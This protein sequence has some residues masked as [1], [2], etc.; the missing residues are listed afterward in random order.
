MDSIIKPLNAKVTALSNHVTGIIYR[1]G[2]GDPNAGAEL[3]A[4]I[5][6]ASNIKADF[7]STIATLQASMKAASGLQNVAIMMKMIAFFVMEIAAAIQLM[8]SIIKLITSIISISSIIA[9]FMK[10][11][12]AFQAA[13]NKAILWLKRKLARVKEKIMKKLEWEKRKITAR[14]MMAYLKASQTAMEKL[15][16]NL[17]PKPPT[18]GENGE[19]VLEDGSLPDTGRYP[20]YMLDSRL[21]YTPGTFIP[22][23]LTDKEK[24]NANIDA[25]ALELVKARLESTKEE[26]KFYEKEIE[27]SSGNID[28]D[29]G[30]YE[31]KWDKETKEDQ[32][33]ITSMFKPLPIPS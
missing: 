14:V 24:L 5:V 31:K 19:Y 7:Q 28:L 16:E 6:S 8:S 18:E 29:K 1:Y 13:M 10:E 15:A 23:P 22:Y 27:P 2:M 3:D 4:L 20:S 12:M 11:I 25:K 32:E 33:F 26:I 9:Y 17:K 30:R 21:T